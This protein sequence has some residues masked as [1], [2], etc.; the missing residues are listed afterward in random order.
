MVRFILVRHGETDYNRQK[1]IMGWKAIPLND[2]GKQQAHLLGKRLAEE[3]L[4][5]VTHVFS[6]DLL[7]AQQ[8]TQILY[9]YLPATLP[10]TYLDG[11]R[12]RKWGSFEGKTID[13]LR[14]EYQRTYNIAPPD[15][16]TR[17]TFYHRCIKTFQ[18]IESWKEWRNQTIVL[19]VTHGGTI[20]QLLRGLLK[21]SSELGGSF[22]ASINNCSITIIKHKKLEESQ[23][24]DPKFIYILEKLNDTCH[25]S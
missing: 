21:T 3:Y 24:N 1:R 8:T 7:R 6:S 15:A 23:S 2:R 25:L 14:R 5:S 22:P 16:E 19:I 4:S 11:L 10:L 12:E 18:Q 17:E 9:Q 13:E 20:R